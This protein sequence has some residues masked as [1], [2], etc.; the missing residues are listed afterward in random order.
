MFDIG[1]SELLLIAV[2]GLLVLGPE[3]LPTAVRTTSLWVGRLRRQFNQIRAEVERE[4]GADE[5][6]AQLRNESILDDLRQSREALESSAR[7]ITRTAHRDAASCRAP[8]CRQ[9]RQNAVNTREP[10]APEQETDREMPLIEH[11]TE[12]RQRLINVIVALLAVFLSLVY[13]ANHIYSFV[14]EPLRRFLPDGATMI[15]TEVAS[16]F[17]A[18]FK[19]TLVVAAM[20]VMP[21]VLFQA[22]AFV[23]PGMY[24]QE[25]RFALPLLAS[26]IVLFYSGVAFAYYV[27]CPMVFGFFTSVSP[28]GV[29]VMTDIN[30]YLN[31]VLTMFFAFGFAFEIPVATVLLVWAGIT[32]PQALTSKRPYIVVG[33]FVIGMV[34]TPPD[35]F[36]QTLLAVPMWMLFEVGVWASRWL[37]ATKA[38]DDAA[39]E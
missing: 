13:F 22:W 19:L 8:R 15:A 3:R 32:T 18:P 6:R 29:T 21:Y 7:E 10:P 16:P 23:A 14:A 33:C 27:V 30:H 12:L 26:S 2:I 24:R 38:R 36:S 20:V 37:L 5:I 9:S 28:A 25:K 34:L 11:L 17:L 35:V 1:F 39:T 31:F 4:I